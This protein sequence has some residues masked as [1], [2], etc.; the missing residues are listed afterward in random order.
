MNFLSPRADDSLLFGLGGGG[1][2]QAQG[3]GRRKEKEGAVRQKDQRREAVSKP[4]KATVELQY[5]PP[6]PEKQD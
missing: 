4:P 2:V 1:L 3:E 6:W 5:L